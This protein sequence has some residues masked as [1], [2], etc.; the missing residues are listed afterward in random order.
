MI[1][2]HCTIIPVVVLYSVI[3]HTSTWFLDRDI[4]Q[5]VYTH[6]RFVAGVIRLERLH[7]F[8]Q[9]LWR[10]CHGNVFM[11]HAEI[12]EHLEDPTTVCNYLL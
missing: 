8:E 7:R 3:T 5:L 6:F 2:F 4:H 1:S 11:R 9:V 12:Y 10:A